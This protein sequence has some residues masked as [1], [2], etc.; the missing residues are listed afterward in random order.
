MPKASTSLKNRKTIIIAGAA[1]FSALVA[2]VEYLSLAIPW[3]RISFPLL[4]QFNL[5]FDMAE[6]PAILSFFIYG[7]PTGVFTSAIVPLTIIIR[8]TANPLGAFLKGTA[9]LTTT[10]GLAPL[11]RKNKYISA[12]LGTTSRVSIMTIINLVVLQLL[13]GYSLEATLFFLP[14]IALFNLIHGILTTV[15]AYTIYVVLLRSRMPEVNR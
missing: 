3:L 11:W 6:V 8:G 10:V 2:I 7:F 13:Y 14:A 9:V 15:V 12:I 4:P 5:K 1:L